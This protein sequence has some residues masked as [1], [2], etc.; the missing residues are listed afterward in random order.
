MVF[1]NRVPNIGEKFSN[2]E[3]LKIVNLKDFSK[4]TG[5][6]AFVKCSC[7]TEFGP[8]AIS[9]LY[10]YKTCKPVESCKPCSA[11]IAGKKMRAND[12]AR[13][14]LFVY[15]NYKN[16]AKKRNIEF[17]I[18]KNIFYEIIILPCVYC[19][20]SKMSYSNPPKEAYWGKQFRY[21][22][23]DRVDPNIGYLIDNI[24]PC[25]IK[26]NR[27][28]SDMKEEDFFLWIEKIVNNLKKDSNA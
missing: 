11:K 6:G 17:D 22:G 7:G 10:G 16:H 13:A 15:G 14:K 18:P 2:L 1:K 26:C 12:D 19:G 5:K 25:C 21:T 24:Q 20:D 3:I 23:I 27:A 28:K 8:V 4:G 9:K